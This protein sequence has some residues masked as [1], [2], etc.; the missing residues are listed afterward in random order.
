[1]V[2]LL[3]SKMGITKVAP[4][5]CHEND[6]SQDLQHVQHRAGPALSSRR[7]S[8][9]PVPAAQRLSSCTH[10]H[11]STD[12]RVLFLQIESE[13]PTMPVQLFYRLLGKQICEKLTPNPKTQLLNPEFHGKKRKTLSGIRISQACTALAGNSHLNRNELRVRGHKPLRSPTVL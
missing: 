8:A 10:H 6:S 9:Q 3:H 13:M 2:P 12:R 11:E 1:M 7:D 4:P 5:R